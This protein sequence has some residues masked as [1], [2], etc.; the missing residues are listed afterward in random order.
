MSDIR[1]TSYWHAVKYICALTGASQKE[2]AERG[3]MTQAMLSETLRKMRVGNKGS[4]NASITIATHNAL[5][6]AFPELETF[7]NDG[8]LDIHSQVRYPKPKPVR[9]A[10]VTSHSATAAIAAPPPSFDNDPMVKMQLSMR[11]LQAKM[12]AMMDASGFT[13]TDIENI[14]KGVRA[15]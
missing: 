11:V 7:I 2:R 14:I 9:I 13:K 15:A 12:D 5:I 10:R 6:K 8:A 3:G 4:K 1:F